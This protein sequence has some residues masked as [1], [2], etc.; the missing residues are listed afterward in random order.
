MIKRNRYLARL[1]FLLAVTLILE[2]IGLPQ[3]FT[4]PLVNMML[5]LTALILGLSA[6]VGL[7]A[8]T[9]IVALLRGQL[10][11][12]LAPMVPFIAVGNGL[13]VA[14]FSLFGQKFRRAEG[15]GIAWGAAGLG[16][17]LGAAAKAGFLYGSALKLLPLIVG[18]SLPAHLIGMMALPQFVT[19]VFGGLGA[20]VLF[21]LIRLRYPLQF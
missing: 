6:G 20:L 11:A 1:V 15:E 7:G 14:C 3:P 2:L 5:I 19:A 17:L 16:L 4:G 9:P 10:P 21:R 12:M 18:R 13:L 8:L